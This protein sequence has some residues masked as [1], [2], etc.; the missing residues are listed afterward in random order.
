M[1]D[2]LMFPVIGGG[3]LVEPLRTGD[4]VLSNDPTN[5]PMWKGLPAGHPP[6]HNYLGLPI[7]LGKELVGVIGL[8]NSSEG[9]WRDD[10]ANL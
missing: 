7:F 5:H 9:F 3:L 2:D 6:I 10:F 4:F 1:S 8:A